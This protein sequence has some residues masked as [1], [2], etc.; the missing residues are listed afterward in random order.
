M[1]KLSLILMILG[2]LGLLYFGWAQYRMGPSGMLDKKWPRPFP[3]P[4]TW[5]NALNNWYDARY[6]APPGHIKL[7]GEIF[8]VR[9]TL[10]IILLVC[11][12]M[13]TTSIAPSTLRL[14][15]NRKQNRTNHFTND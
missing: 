6:P 5:L 12:A 1:K 2:I 10:Y 13:V 8:R 4:D 7:H 14:I 11:A 3:Y 9:A 15:K